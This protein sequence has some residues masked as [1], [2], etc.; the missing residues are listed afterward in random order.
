M[1]TNKP[2]LN[3]QKQV[4]QNQEDIENLQTTLTAP[5]LDAVTNVSYNSTDGAIIDYDNGTTQHLPIVP[6]NGITIDATTDNKHLEIKVGDN[7]VVPAESSLTISA[8]TGAEPGQFVTFD[9]VNSCIDLEGS[10]V[11]WFTIDGDSDAT[12]SDSA[13]GPQ[14]TAISGSAIGS[15][16]EITRWIPVCPVYTINSPASATNGT[17]PNDKSYTYLKSNPETLKILFNKEFYQ[18]A[19]N[20]HTTG[21]LVFSHVGYE[22]SQLIVKTITITIATRAWVLTTI[23][24]ATYITQASINL[25]GNIY[26]GSPLPYNTDGISYKQYYDAFPEALPISGLFSYGGV[27]YASES[28]FFDFNDDTINGGTVNAYKVSDGSY[29]QLQFT[30]TQ[31]YIDELVTVE[32]PN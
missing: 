16:G 31:L 7:I 28:I 5:Q 15:G 3:L 25:L 8:Y 24:P 32:L 4:L 10:G 21:T 17:L 11:T 19:D 20:Q 12:Y 29:V 14:I 1:W 6:G 22:G 13:L 30:A 27:V 26:Y 18:L 23:K 9:Q 2:P